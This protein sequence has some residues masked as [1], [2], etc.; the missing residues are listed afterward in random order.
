MTRMAFNRED[1]LSRDQLADE[2][3]RKAANK[4]PKASMINQAEKK[5]SQVVVPNFVKPDPQT[6][7]DQS[8]EEK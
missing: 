4:K 8:S 5:N 2:N 6:S 3:F 7:S 1:D